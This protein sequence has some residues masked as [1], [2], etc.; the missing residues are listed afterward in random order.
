[1]EAWLFA[2]EHNASVICDRVKGARDARS[3]I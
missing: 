2:R 3:E 1:L